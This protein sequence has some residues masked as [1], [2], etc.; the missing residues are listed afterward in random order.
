MWTGFSFVDHLCF[1]EGIQQRYT[2]Y[3]RHSDITPSKVQGCQLAELLR[4]SIN[5]LF[6]LRFRVDVGGVDVV[7]REKRWRAVALCSRRE[8]LFRLCGSAWLFLPMGRREPPTH[9][10]CAVPKNL[11]LV[12]R[13]VSS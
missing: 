3:Q 8:A 9:M 12:E 13:F 2:V 1:A 6:L 11:P 5:S 4:E 7:R 10:A